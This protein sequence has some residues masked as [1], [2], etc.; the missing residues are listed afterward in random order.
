MRSLLVSV[1]Y[2]F[3]EY[4]MAIE[5]KI[6]EITFDA[7]K[8]RGGNIA[9][10]EQTLAQMLSEGWKIIASGGAGMGYGYNNPDYNRFSDQEKGISDYHL[11]GFVILQREY[12]PPSKPVTLNEHP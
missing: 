2:E 6:I 10:V 4:T 1:D 11:L 12:T 7:E 5:V 9:K 8:Y 3:T